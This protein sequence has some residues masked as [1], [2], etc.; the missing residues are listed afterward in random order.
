MRSLLRRQLNAGLVLSIIAIILAL[1]GTATAASLITSAQIKNNSITSADIK[2]RSITGTDIKNASISSA[3]IKPRAVAAQ[4]LQPA[5]V[6]ELQATPTS[7]VSKVEQLI[8]ASGTSLVSGTATCPE[9]QV[10]LGGGGGL[11]LGPDNGMVRN[12]K[13]VLDAQNVARGWTMTVQVL[14]TPPGVDPSTEALEVYVIC[15]P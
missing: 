12:T 14:T 9:G 1:G 6:Q 8:P 15:S 2:N 3:D 5:T 13:P 4:A 7:T 11:K 10:A